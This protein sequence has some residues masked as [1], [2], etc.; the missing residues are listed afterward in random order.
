MMDLS[1]EVLCAILGQQE[2]LK[3]CCVSVHRFTSFKDI[4]RHQSEQFNRPRNTEPQFISD[5]H[6]LYM[7]CGTGVKSVWGVRPNPDPLFSKA[8]RRYRKELFLLRDG[9]GE[10]REM[11]DDRSVT[12]RITLTVAVVTKTETCKK[13]PSIDY[14]L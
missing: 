1:G 6:F 12:S 11:T 7:K 5:T 10:P 14:Q 4:F 3:S 2:C 8:L 9:Q 13:L